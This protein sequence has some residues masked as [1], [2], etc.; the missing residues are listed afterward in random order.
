MYTHTHTSG[1]SINGAFNIICPQH[2][3]FD[4]TALHQV[5]G[6][7][8]RLQSVPALSQE[9]DLRENTNEFSTQ[10]ALNISVYLLSVV[11]VVC[12][13][14]LCFLPC[15][16]SGRRSP[17][18]S[19]G[20][21]QGDCQHHRKPAPHYHSSSARLWRKDTEKHNQSKVHARSH[22][23]SHY[24]MLCFNLYCKNYTNLLFWSS[25]DSA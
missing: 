3:L 22:E 17:S 24:K 16:E 9:D 13:H 7:H 2:R 11:S 25:C 12:Q 8:E 14:E 1:L 20:R 10:S 6:H 18:C 21:L 15:R 23:V 19:S 5:E 4:L